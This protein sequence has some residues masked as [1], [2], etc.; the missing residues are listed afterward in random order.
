[1]TRESIALCR[2]SRPSRVEGIFNASKIA[3]VLPAAIVARLLRENP[4]LVELPIAAV[5]VI[6]TVITPVRILVLPAF[7]VVATAFCVVLAIPA[8]LGIGGIRE[9]IP[10]SCRW[11]ACRACLLNIVGLR[12]HRSRCVA[13][14]CKLIL[15]PDELTQVVPEDGT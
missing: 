8:L 1:M 11:R 10:G 4:G 14:Q 15:G 13:P 9:W 12:N 6:I 5:L 2:I 7:L 3:R